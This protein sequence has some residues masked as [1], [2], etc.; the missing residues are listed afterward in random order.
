MQFDNSAQVDHLAT[1]APEPPKP[2]PKW[3]GWSAPLRAVP[4]AVAEMGAS[5][6]E[7]LKAFGQALDSTGTAGAGGMFAAQTPAE[8]QQSDSVRQRITATG[9]TGDSEA[10]R[11]LRGVSDYYSPDPATASRAEQMVF[12]AV[13]GIGKAVAYGLTTGPA[14]PLLFGLDEGLTQA[15][16]LQRQGVDNVTAA[17]AGMVAGAVNAGG[18]AIP[19]AGA[20]VGRT[21][22]LAMLSGPASFIAQQVATREVLR[23][24]N[25]QEIGEQFDPLDPYGLALSALPFGFGAWAM[26]ARM[27]GAKATAKAEA[28]APPGA[29]AAEHVD[30]AP[31]AREG[32]TAP[33]EAVDAAM[34]HNL[35]LA[36]Q[37]AEQ[38]AELRAILARAPEPPRVEAARQIDAEIAGLVEQREQLLPQAADLVDRGAVRAM[39]EEL[40]ALEQQRPDASDAGMRAAAKEIQAQERVS[41]KAALSQA[42]RQVDGQVADFEARVAR[43]EEAVQRNAQ[44]QQAFDTLQQIDRSI[45]SARELRD[46][47]AP[48]TAFRNPIAEAARQAIDEAR[49]STTRAAPAQ[50]A[51]DQ[52]AHVPPTAAMGE[53]ARAPR[54]PE[55]PQAG[56]QADQAAAAVEPGDGPDAALIQSVRARGDQ[57]VA[58]AP[59]LVVGATEDGKPITAREAL[60]RIRRESAEG[61]DGELGSQDAP[62]LD[63]AIQCALSHGE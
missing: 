33:H 21:F 18:F 53:E 25:Y 36:G 28:E 40:A 45:A 60:E 42:R 32:G 41:Y 17:R 63:V 52:T 43:L 35:T 20:T 26:R 51:G 54:S 1:L 37:A 27:R 11:A 14:A 58:E 55:S 49:P 50:T 10:S 9:M 31:A 34:V 62:L 44:A 57:V 15:D 39:R 47:V 23:S 12:G 3:N 24:A 6:G 7:S 61:S 22:A 59:D 16:Q 56:Q 4:A 5:L 29:A 46:V 30:V 2:V 48:F 38:H 8:R 13:R 19:V